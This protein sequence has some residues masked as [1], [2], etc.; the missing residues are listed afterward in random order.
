MR[1]DDDR[2]FEQEIG[3]TP[4]PYGTW[5]ETDLYQYDLTDEDQVDR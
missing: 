1:T 3:L 2:I 4:G 5:I